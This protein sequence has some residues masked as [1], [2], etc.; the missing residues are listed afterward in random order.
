[1]RASAV[2]LTPPLIVTAPE[3]SRI[4]EAVADAVNRIDPETFALPA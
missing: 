2:V 1:M 3:V 4:C